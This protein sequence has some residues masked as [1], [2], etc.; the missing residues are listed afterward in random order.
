MAKPKA[1][2]ED[3]VKQLRDLFEQLLSLPE[4]DPT[5]ER[6]AERFRLYKKFTEKGMTAEDRLGKLT[7]G[8]L[9]AFFE[10]GPLGEDCR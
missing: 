1:L 10:V 8:E 2:P 9:L 4:A 7:N 5:K 3:S 6:A